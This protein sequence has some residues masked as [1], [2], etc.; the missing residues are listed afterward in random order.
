MNIKKILSASK[1]ASPAASRFTER[2]IVRDSD[3]SEIGIIGICEAKSVAEFQALPPDERVRAMC[4]MRAGGMSIR[5]IVRH[6]GVS[7]GIV[8]G[9]GRAGGPDL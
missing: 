9:I 3:G 8:R 6:T 7:F 1:R 5:Q 2:G 4:L